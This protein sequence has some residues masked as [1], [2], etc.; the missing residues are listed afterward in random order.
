MDMPSQQ[1][2]FKRKLKA[3]EQELQSLRQALLL[4]KRKK[5]RPISLEGIWKGVDISDKDI[6]EAKAS[7]FRHQL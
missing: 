2:T 1:T 6:E 4:S 3:L 5:G 7:L